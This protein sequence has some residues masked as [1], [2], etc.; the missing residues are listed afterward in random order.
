MFYG[1][2]TSPANHH[3]SGR[4]F[5]V[6]LIIYITE[7]FPPP[8][9]TTNL[10]ASFI[11]TSPIIQKAGKP[12]SLR[13][14]VPWQPLGSAVSLAALLFR[15]TFWRTFG[16][17]FRGSHFWPFRLIIRVHQGKSLAV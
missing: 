3:Q 15:R 17:T 14:A 11:L 2:D 8:P 4:P 6:N 1:I 13:L 16:R 9:T 10:V 5:S 7:K 12:F